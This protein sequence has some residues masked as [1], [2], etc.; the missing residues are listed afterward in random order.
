MWIMILKMAAATALYVLATVLLWKSWH[1]S[2]TH[3]LLHKLTIGLFYGLCS[4]ASSHIGIDYGN[5]LLNVRD[6]GPLAAGLNQ[7]KNGTQEQILDGM[8]RSI[9]SFA[10]ETEQFDDITMLGITYL[11]SISDA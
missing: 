5:M 8:L 4:I 3:T 9:R 11:D 7:L 10:G 6:L 2:S 1:K